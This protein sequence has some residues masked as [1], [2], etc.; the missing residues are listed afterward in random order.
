MPVGVGGRCSGNEVLITTYRRLSGC[1][2]RI[3]LAL[4]IHSV[5]GDASDP[6]LMIRSFQGDIQEVRQANHRY[7]KTRVLWTFLHV[8][9]AQYSCTEISICDLTSQLMAAGAHPNADS[10]VGMPL[11]DASSPACRALVSHKLIEL[12][13]NGRVML[14]RVGLQQVKHVVELVGEPN[15]LF[16]PRSDVAL[17]NQTAWEL[18]VALEAESWIW[19]PWKPP[20]QRSSTDVIPLEYRRGDALTFYTTLCPSKAYL[21]TLLAS[22]SLFNQGMLAIVHGVRDDNYYL[23]L[24]NGDFSEPLLSLPDVEVEDAI[25]EGIA[26][27]FAANL[28]DAFDAEMQSSDEDNEAALQ[29][30]QASVLLDSDLEALLD[31]EPFRFTFKNTGQH[32]AFEARCPFHRKNDRSH[33]KKTLRLSGPSTADRAATLHRLRFWCICALDHSRQRFHV[34]ET[35]PEIDALP[36]PDFVLLAQLEKPDGKVFTDTQLDMLAVPLDLVPPASWREAERRQAS[37]ESSNH[38]LVQSSRTRRADE[39]AEALSAD[40]SSSSTSSSSSSSSD[41]SSNKSS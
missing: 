21:R 18:L 35:P 1:G 4:Q 19:Y 12:L 24:L 39:E 33:C 22:E 14:T 15:L 16:D 36:D 32:G 2:D 40:S 29:E 23:R 3:V 41:S 13:P 9:A 26:A 8:D 6:L 28:E 31:L 30:E 10:I 20:S 17:A 7:R 37:E 34:W 25:A 5:D 11:L 27:Q 38:E